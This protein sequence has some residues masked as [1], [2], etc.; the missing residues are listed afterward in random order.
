MGC[1][2]KDSVQSSVSKVVSFYNET[3]KVKATAGDKLWELKTGGP[4]QFSP[5]SELMEQFTS[6]QMTNG[7][8]P[9]R[10][11]EKAALKVLGQCLARLPNALD[12]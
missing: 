2:K 4:V 12:V 10:P 9:S 3:T 5:L 1:E 6:D 7:S 8:M 11:I